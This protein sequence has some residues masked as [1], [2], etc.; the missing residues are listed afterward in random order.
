MVALEKVNGDYQGTTFPGGHV[1]RDETF[2]DPIIREVREE[3]GLDIEEPNGREG[4]LQ[5]VVYICDIVSSI[6]VA[7]LNTR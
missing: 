2:T 6:C 3:T 1:E 4:A 7:Y 5:Y